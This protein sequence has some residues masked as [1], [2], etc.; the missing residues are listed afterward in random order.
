[1]IAD[2]VESILRVNIPLVLTHFPIGA[3]LGNI[4]L[5]DQCVFGH[6]ACASIHREWRT[7]V[8]AKLAH[9]VNNDAVVVQDDDVVAIEP[10]HLAFDVSGLVEF[11]GG[12]CVHDDEHIV[13]LNHPF[14]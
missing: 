3:P 2:E 5:A 13:C 9:L 14:Q 12:Q 4:R 11:G 8:R 1:M 7:W 10:C 6:F